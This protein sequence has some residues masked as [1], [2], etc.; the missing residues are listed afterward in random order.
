MSCV[1]FVFLTH[2][3]QTNSH[4]SG[5]LSRSSSVRKKGHLIII[6]TICP[7]P[8]DLTALDTDIACS[9]SLSLQG[10]GGEDD[11]DTLSREK[12][13]VRKKTGFRSDKGGDGGEPFVMRTKQQ[14]SS[15]T[16]LPCCRVLG[17]PLPLTCMQASGPQYCHA[18][19]APQSE[20]YYA[21]VS[22]FDPI[23]CWED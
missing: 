8:Q 6:L 1:P 13:G 14:V 10:G 11:E 16:S 5:S 7:G 9:I 17:T 23:P 21:H 18:C 2:A 12:R 22:C 20:P 19:K 3:L 4:T 15:T